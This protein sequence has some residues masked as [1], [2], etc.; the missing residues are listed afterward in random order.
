MVRLAF[1]N[2]NKM[3]FG[4][5]S[6]TWAAQYSLFVG[7]PLLLTVCCLQAGSRPDPGWNW[8]GDNKPPAHGLELP[9]LSLYAP[10]SDVE[11]HNWQIWIS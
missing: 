9:A 5:H 4:V 11:E 8:P 10:M 2:T 7:N 1:N 3:Y 6:Y